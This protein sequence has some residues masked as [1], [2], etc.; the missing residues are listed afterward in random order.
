[1]PIDI[2]TESVIHVRELPKLLGPIGRK[3]SQLHQS[4]VM[5]AIL[6]GHNGTRLEAFKCGS[7]WLTSVEAVERWL[8]AQASRALDAARTSAPAPPPRKAAELAGRRL[9]EIGL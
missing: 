2:K 9:D 4:F 3:G 6:R 5:R 8:E 1:M 7:R